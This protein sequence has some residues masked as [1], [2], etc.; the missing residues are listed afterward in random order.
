MNHFRTERALYNNTTKH[1]VNMLF[2]EI[3][4]LTF[5]YK[6][7]D[8]AA[9]ASDYSK[10]TVIR[11][12]NVKFSMRDTDLK[13][14]LKYFNDIE[15][16]KNLSKNDKIYLNRISIDNQ[17]IFMY[18]RRMMTTRSLDNQDRILLQKLQKDMKV[19]DPKLRAMLTL[20]VKWESLTGEE[21]RLL[22][23]RIKNYGLLHL[24]NSEMSKA[25]NKFSKQDSPYVNDEDKKDPRVT[26]M[27]VMMGAFTGMAAK[28]AHDSRARNKQSFSRLHDETKA[29][30]Y[31]D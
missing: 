3:L 19:D 10:R 13:A 14:M 26:P 6:V 11:P 21:M 29:G 22:V 18:L 5:M 24:R 4:R 25:M 31:E 15:S 1:M 23:D 2:F 9:H 7:Y 27:D 30:R 12:M 20:V 17:R 8:L 28:W 16:N